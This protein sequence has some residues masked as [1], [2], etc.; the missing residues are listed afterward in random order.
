MQSIRNTFGKALIDI[1]GKN[2]NVMVVTAELMGATRCDGFARAYPERFFDVGIAEQN[3]F[4]I[5]AG[6]ASCGKIP[7]VCSY[8]N[9][10]CLRA[11]EQIRNDIAYTNM[12]VKIVALSSGLTF[13]V[14]GATHQSYEDLSVMRAL[15]NFVVIAPADAASLDAAIHAA[16]NR[17]GPV[18]I[19]AGRDAEY[20]VHAGGVDFQIGKAIQMREGKDVCIIASGYMVHEAL[21]SA[22]RLAGEG[23]SARVLDMHTIKP[24]DAE[25]IRKAAKECKA[26]VTVEEHNIFGGLGSAVLEALEGGHEIPVRRIGIEDE[27]PIIGPTFEL[28][29]HL[30][31]HADTIYTTALGILREKTGNH[32]GVAG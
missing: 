13:G 14:G 20:I 30:G 1:G 3:A 15:P 21:C 26:I 9:F 28:R 22:D 12:N 16:I 17:Q 29:K 4:G 10:A 32:S 5:A 11:G 31:L 24:I 23:L 2:K 19:R 8:A 18:F 25:A 7:I 27:F 6:M